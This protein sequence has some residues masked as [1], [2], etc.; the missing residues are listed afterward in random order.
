MLILITN[1][2]CTVWLI[3]CYKCHYICFFSKFKTNLLA[4]NYSII[5][6]NTW[7]ADVEKSYKIAVINY[8]TSVIN[9]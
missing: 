3:C 1:G 6:A 8:N 4:E 2:Q 9:K 7:F 5:H